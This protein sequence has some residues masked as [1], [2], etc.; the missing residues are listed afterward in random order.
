MSTNLLLKVAFFLEVSFR[1]FSKALLCECLLSVIY[2]SCLEGA[3]NGYDLFNCL[4]V[5]FLEYRSLVVEPKIHNSSHTTVFAQV[6]LVN[7][8]RW[9]Y[10]PYPQEQESAQRYQISWWW[11]YLLLKVF[12]S[13]FCIQIVENSYNPKYSIPFRSCIYEIMVI[14]RRNVISRLM[15]NLYKSVKQTNKYH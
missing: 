11:Y 15:V 14:I 4:C 5:S 13:D 6:I 9:V 8:K 3:S 7:E 2:C 10:L 1:T 12:R